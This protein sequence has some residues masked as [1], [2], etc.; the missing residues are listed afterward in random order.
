MPTAQPTFSASLEDPNARRRGAVSGRRTRR[1]YA[2]GIAAEL[3]FATLH[4][5]WLVG[6]L[7]TNE[8]ASLPILALG[9]LAG[10]ALGDAISGL[11]HWACD[12]WGS[13]ETPIVGAGLIRWF[14]EHHDRP[15][16]ILD[17]DAIEI[18]G[19][20]ALAAAAALGLAALPGIR[21]AL[22]QAPALYALGL[23]AVVSAAFAN[24]AHQWAH[25]PRAPRLV[26]G[27]QRRGLLLSP[28]HHLQHHRPP[29]IG[30]YCITGGWLNPL[31]DRGAWRGLERAIQWVTGVPPREDRGSEPTPPVS[32][33][34][35]PRTLAK[36]G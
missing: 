31:L 21:D 36:D 20:G 28:G 12:T 7:V 25:T 27:L 29:H 4:T 23:A 11:V 19:Q 9:V 10:V 18:H 3:L 15:A 2:A 30:R 17:H 1:L 26:R 13:P 35:R 16:S 34:T 24:Q 6:A 5:T 14:R 32:R 22:L 33:E 8:A